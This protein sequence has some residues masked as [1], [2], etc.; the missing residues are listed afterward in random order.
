MFSEVY[1]A[2]K[3]EIKNHWDVEF[4]FSKEVEKNEESI[5]RNP[6]LEQFGISFDVRILQ[7][8]E[9]ARS[10]QDILSEIGAR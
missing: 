4:V 2:P 10:H 9:F 1:D 5:S 3:Y 6:A 8:K 7:D